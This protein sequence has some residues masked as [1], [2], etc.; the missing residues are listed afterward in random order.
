MSWGNTYSTTLTKLR[1]RQNKCIKNIFFASRRENATPHYNLFSV[2]K[3]DNIFKLKIGIF[4]YKIIHDKSNIPALFS[5]TIQLAST[6]HSYNTRFAGKQNFSRTKARINY[7]VHTFNFV[8]S[9]IWQS[10]D[11]EIKLS[12][13][14][15]I[16]RKKYIKSLLLSQKRYK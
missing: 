16:F 9:R 8:S 14:V 6:S 4:T 12:N 3:F 10:I 7:G 1:S 15:N 11:P 2:L 5:Q 13:S